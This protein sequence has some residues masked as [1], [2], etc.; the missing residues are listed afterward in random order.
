MTKPKKR[1]IEKLLTLPEVHKAWER[2]WSNTRI[3][4]FTEDEHG[5]KQAIRTDVQRI[6]PE[7]YG[8]LNFKNKKK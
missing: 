1:K 3:L 6:M 5:D 2:F 8:S 4:G 7:N